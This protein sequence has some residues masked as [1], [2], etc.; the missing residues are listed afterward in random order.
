[1][2]CVVREVGSGALNII[3]MISSRSSDLLSRRYQSRP[4]AR[5]HECF[6]EQSGAGTSFAPSAVLTAVSCQWRIVSLLR[7]Y[8][9]VAL[10]RGQEAKLAT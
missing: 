2:Q 5:P 7:T 6:G 8:L 9:G 1:M 10:V 3:Y 4:H